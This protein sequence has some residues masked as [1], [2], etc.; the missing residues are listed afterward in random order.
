[1]T[2]PE[3]FYG[4]EIFLQGDTALLMTS[5]WTE[6]PFLSRAA[7]ASWFPGSPTGRIMEIDLAA[8]TIERTLEFEGSYL[9]AREI[10]GSIR[11][12]MSAAENRFNFVFPSNPGAEDAAEQANRDLIAESTIDMWIPPSGSPTAPP[13]GVRPSRRARSSPATGSTCPPS[14]PAS[15]RWWC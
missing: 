1:M 9:S 5:G 2:L 4:G 13:V 11:I 8:G 12:V 3:E 7:D 6:Q 15:A 10:D 14:S